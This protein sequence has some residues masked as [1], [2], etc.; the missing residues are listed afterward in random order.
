MPIRFLHCCCAAQWDMVKSG[1]NPTDVHVLIDLGF[2]I[3]SRYGTDSNRAAVDLVV[4][5][6]HG[7][8]VHRE[9]GSSETEIAGGWMGGGGGACACMA[10]LGVAGWVALPAVSP[11]MSPVRPDPPPLQYPPRARRGP[12]RRASKC[13]AVRY[14]TP[15]R[16]A[17]PL[18][19]ARR[20]PLALSAATA[21]TSGGQRALI[22]HLPLADPAV[23]P[24][25]ASPRLAPRPPHPCRSCGPR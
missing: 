7:D 20:Q 22:I 2:V 8:V 24:H 14:A 13:P 12:G 4:Y 11:V 6:P 25:P 5:G 19:A 18:P 17:R 15:P 1:E 21:A 9:H 10:E 16:P 23:S 3:T